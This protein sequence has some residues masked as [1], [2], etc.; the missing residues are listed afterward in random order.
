MFGPLTWPALGHR[1]QESMEGLRQ[2]RLYE[3]NSELPC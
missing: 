3:N 2:A 1:G